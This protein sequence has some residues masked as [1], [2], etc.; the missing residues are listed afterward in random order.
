VEEDVNTRLKREWTGRRVTV[1][2]TAP[3]LARFRGRT[4]EVKTV[5]QNGRALVQFS[6]T[7][8]TGWYDIDLADLRLVTES[9]L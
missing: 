6:G 8:D 5:N 9:T 4:G 2:S 1:E 7:E 3:R